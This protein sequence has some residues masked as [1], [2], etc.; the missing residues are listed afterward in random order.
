MSDKQP[1]VKLHEVKSSNV[2]ALGYDAP[3]MRMAVQ[4]KGGATYQ[5]NGVDAKTADEVQSAE[6]VGSAVNRLLVRG[7]FK[8]ERLGEKS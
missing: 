3:S 6:S 1:P 8:Y 5:Y 7:K 2:A 4:F